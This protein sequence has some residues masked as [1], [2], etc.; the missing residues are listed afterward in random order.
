MNSWPCTSSPDE[1]RLLLLVAAEVYFSGFDSRCA[2]KIEFSHRD[3]LS[4]AGSERGRIGSQMKVI[5]GRVNKP[6]IRKMGMTVIPRGINISIES[7]RG[8]GS[9]RPCAGLRT[10]A[11]VIKVVINGY[12][13]LGFC[14]PETCSPR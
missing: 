12:S 14:R 3:V 10:G 1:T 9:F 4:C 8:G 7:R 13:W 2:F 6:R 5:P 11:A